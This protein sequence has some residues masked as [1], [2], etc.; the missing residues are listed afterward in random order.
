MVF[1]YK[2]N[3]AECKTISF[4]NL[5]VYFHLF[6]WTH[7][8]NKLNYK[9]DNHLTFF[10]FFFFFCRPAAIPPP[11]PRRLPGLIV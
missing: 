3:S 7:Q 10:F 8:L 1:I 2:K 11:P 6:E 5:L 9:H 4:K